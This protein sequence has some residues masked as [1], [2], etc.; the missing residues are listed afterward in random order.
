MRECAVLFS[1]LSVRQQ[2]DAMVYQAW[3]RCRGCLYFP[4]GIRAFLTVVL[5]RVPLLNRPVSLS[6]IYCKSLER[7]VIE[8]VFECV[9]SYL[10]SSRVFVQEDPLKSNS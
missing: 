2:H 9:V 7:I 5:V 10:L 4:Q 1:T 8:L 3:R 6:S